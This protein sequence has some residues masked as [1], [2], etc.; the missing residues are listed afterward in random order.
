[1]IKV[2][3]MKH[4][5]ICLVI[6]LIIIIVV[7]VVL[8]ISNSTGKKQ[9]RQVKQVQEDYTKNMVISPKKDWGINFIDSKNDKSYTVQQWNNQDYI[10]TSYYVPI[11][12]CSDCCARFSVMKLDK[13]NSF[14]KVK[15]EDKDYKSGI[16]Y[17]EKKYGNYILYDLQHKKD[18]KQKDYA[19]GT[20]SGYF[21]KDGFVWAYKYERYEGVSEKIQSQLISDVLNNIKIIK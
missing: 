15:E 9:G 17:T 6:I 4:W 3:N 10:V 11:K 19:E 20:H 5:Q 13:K 21:K 12:R 16:K 8:H 14:E 2:N 18:L 7:T 1:M